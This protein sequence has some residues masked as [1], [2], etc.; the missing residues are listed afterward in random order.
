MQKI[1][2]FI[3]PLILL[4]YIITVIACATT[5]KTKTVVEKPGFYGFDYGSRWNG[6]NGDVNGEV[7]H[8]LDI[9]GPVASC[10]PSHNW[11]GNSM[12][13]SG[14][15][16]PGLALNDASHIIGIPTER[17]HWI[18]KMKMYNV[19]CQGSIMM[20]LSRNCV[21]ISPAVVK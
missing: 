19:T 11:S 2:I 9:I 15:L 5:H 16:P 10:L 14:S 17:G 6:G 8:R 3:G 1:R 7:G 4:G 12:I 21:S 20:V 13:V 18:V